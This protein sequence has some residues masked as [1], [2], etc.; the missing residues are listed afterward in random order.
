MLYICVQHFFAK[1]SGV[2]AKVD[3]SV[4]NLIYVTYVVDAHD[5]KKVELGRTQHFKLR[6]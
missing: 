1:P 3:I 4:P 2:T 5:T 6:V